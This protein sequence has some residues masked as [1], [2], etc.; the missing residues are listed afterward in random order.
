MVSINVCVVLCYVS[1]RKK[2]LPSGKLLVMRVNAKVVTLSPLPSQWCSLIYRWRNSSLEMSGD[3]AELTWVVRVQ[4]GIG[5]QVC[6]RQSK[7]ILFIPP[8]LICRHLLYTVSGRQQR[9]RR[10]DVCERPRLTLR[11]SLAACWEWKGEVTE[12]SQEA[13]WDR[14]LPFALYSFHFLSMEPN[15]MEWGD[16]LSHH[17]FPK[18]SVETPIS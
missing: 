9:Q 14:H 1:Y 7:N 2:V 10:M 13:S 11:M 12:A 15:K 8:A 6:Q 17:L 18:G 3:L 5:S 16:W 4:V